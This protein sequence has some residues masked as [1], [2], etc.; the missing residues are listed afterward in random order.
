L[1]TLLSYVLKKCNISCVFL[2]V[3]PFLPGF[4][5]W[6]ES[7]LIIFFRWH[8][9]V[10]IRAAVRARPLNPTE[11]ATGCQTCIVPD[12]NTVHLQGTDGPYK[13]DYVFGPDDYQNCVYDSA[14][15]DFVMKIFEGAMILSYYRDG[16]SLDDWASV[17]KRDRFLFFHYEQS[18][19]GSSGDEVTC[20]TG[21]GFMYLGRNWLIF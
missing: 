13:F 16:Y 19:S 18:D 21:Y 9:G 8:S 4:F 5:F 14:V 20:L 15:Q 6:S 7:E 17:S 1:T 3:L 12:D 11:A 2:R 10:P